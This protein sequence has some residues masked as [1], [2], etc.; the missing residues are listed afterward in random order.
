MPVI[1]LAFM[2]GWS[3]AEYKTIDVICPKC[4]NIIASHVPYLKYT[5]FWAIKKCDKCG[6]M[7]PVS[8]HSL[9]LKNYKEDCINYHSYAVTKGK[10]IYY[11]ST[12]TGKIID[13]LRIDEMC[14]D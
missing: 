14:S 9:D 7:L 3:I 8:G 12:D 13:S 5:Y 4:N 10:T 11:Y 1:I 2:L 6:Y